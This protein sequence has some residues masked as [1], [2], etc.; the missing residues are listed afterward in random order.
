M[1][2][3]VKTAFTCASA[4][5]RVSEYGIL[6]KISTGYGM[7]FGKINGIFWSSKKGCGI[8]RP[9]ID[10]IWNTPIPTP[11]AI[12]ARHP[13]CPVNDQQYNLKSYCRSTNLRSG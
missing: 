8:F 2:S 6:G 3:D 1:L 5:R 9:Q 13:Y 12:R 11:P 4:L 7:S 10:G